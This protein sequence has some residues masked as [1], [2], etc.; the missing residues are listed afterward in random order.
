MET[1]L[2]IWLPASVTN[3]FRANMNK[4][5]V[6][7]SLRSKSPMLCPT[8]FGIYESIELFWRFIC[9]LFLNI[10]FILCHVC[11]IYMYMLDCLYAYVGTFEPD[12]R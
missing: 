4:R 12:Q 1:Q 2:N 8:R 3:L 6:F 5:L 7:I 11:I 9:I 10:L